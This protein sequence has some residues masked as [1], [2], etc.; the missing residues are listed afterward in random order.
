MSRRKKHQEESFETADGFQI[1]D[2]EGN[3]VVDDLLVEDAF[4][5]EAS[6]S[7]AL[8][9]DE[10]DPFWDDDEDDEKE[11]DEYFNSVA[12]NSNWEEG[13]DY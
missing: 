5:S 11:E 7:D 9:E 8:L 1:E 3:A 2:M 13:Y 6:A 4:P 12:E 10:H